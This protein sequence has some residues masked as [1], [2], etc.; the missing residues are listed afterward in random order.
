MPN[1]VIQYTCQVGGVLLEI[2]NELHYCLQCSHDNNRENN[3]S[4]YHMVNTK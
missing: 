4:K 1:K 3:R 2:D